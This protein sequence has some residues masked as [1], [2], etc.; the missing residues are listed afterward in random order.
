M[1]RGGREVAARSVNSLPRSTQSELGKYSALSRAD[2]LH[3]RPQ[4]DGERGDLLG[5]KVESNKK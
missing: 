2:E 5:K 4:K 3:S 1:Q